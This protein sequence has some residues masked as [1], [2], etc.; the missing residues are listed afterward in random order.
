[1]NSMIETSL[2]STNVTANYTKN[3]ETNESDED[4]ELPE[5]WESLIA[6]DGRKFYLNHKECASTSDKPNNTVEA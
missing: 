1:M 3:K 6:N 2:K 5:F 4:E